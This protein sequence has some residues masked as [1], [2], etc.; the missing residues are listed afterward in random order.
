[1]E[2]MFQNE[3]TDSQ[4]INTDVSDMSDGTSQT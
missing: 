3:E 4:Q 2:L 1:M